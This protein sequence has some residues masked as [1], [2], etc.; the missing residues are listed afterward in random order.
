MVA[1]NPQHSTIDT[2]HH[3]L[4]S[5]MTHTL[6][7]AAEPH[8]IHQVQ[9]D[10][11]HGHT[12]V[13]AAMTQVADDSLESSYTSAAFHP[14]GLI[15]GTGMHNSTVLVWEVRSQKVRFS[16]EIVG[17]I[18]QL[19]AASAAHSC[20]QLHSSS[21]QTH[22]CQRPAGLRRHE[23][24]APAIACHLGMQLPA[25]VHH[26][27][28]CRSAE[29]QG[30][31]SGTCAGTKALGPCSHACSAAECVCMSHGAC[32]RMMEAAQH[33]TA[34]SLAEVGQIWHSSIRGPALTPSALQS[35]AKFENHRGPVTSLSFSENGLLPGH[36][37]CR[38]GQAVG[39]A[40]AE[41]LQ[42]PG[43]GGGGPGPGLR[44]QRPVPQ[45]GGGGGCPRV[46]QQAGLGAAVPL[47]RLAQAGTVLPK[48]VSHLSSRLFRAVVVLAAA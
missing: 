33:A 41:E 14:D 3:R 7:P 42:V 6:C 35:V 11:L 23:Q 21:C 24:S 5:C 39:P 27:T 28:A 40:Q 45:R 47:P 20:L 48:A 37:G 2:E 18:A 4:K 25:A 1:M 44:S 8:S 15:L 22:V 32:S 12:L 13:N 30:S 9:A 29:P 36:R 46:R 17:G 34:C 16:T 19:T 10:L 38:R 43:P 31:V 26:T